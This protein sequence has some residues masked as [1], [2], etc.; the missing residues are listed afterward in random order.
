MTTIERQECH[1]T[2]TVDL[3]S[4]ISVDGNFP[5]TQVGIIAIGFL[6][7]V[8]NCKT[9]K[10]LRYHPVSFEATS[11]IS[12]VRPSIMSKSTSDR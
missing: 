2:G 10:T 7:Q 4:R 3:N 9:I 6:S 11:T 12:V 1:L 8:Q 5:M